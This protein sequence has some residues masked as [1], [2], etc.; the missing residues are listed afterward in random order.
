MMR[1]G[2][3]RGP[4]WQITL[5]NQNLVSWALVKVTP[6]L[7]CGCLFNK[8]SKVFQWLKRWFLFLRGFLRNCLFPFAPGIW[9]TCRWSPLA[10]ILHFG[11]ALIPACSV[12]LSTLYIVFWLTSGRV[13][14]T[15]PGR[16][17]GY[18]I[19]LTWD[20]LW[21]FEKM[22]VIF[23]WRIDLSRILFFLSVVC[24]TW[25]CLAFTE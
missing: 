17:G 3:W 20:K 2:T 12:N 8:V 1:G 18:K 6:F 13:A 11:L 25:I 23:N 19:I 15:S 4:T 21:I 14:R 16:F 7:A 10:Q 24:C 5:G 22:V 9:S